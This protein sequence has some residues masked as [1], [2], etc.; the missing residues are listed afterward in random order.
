MR[1]QSLFNCQGFSN[2]HPHGAVTVNKLTVVGVSQPLLVRELNVNQTL[3]ISTGRRCA[4]S[5]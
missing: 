5:K 1:D 3:L 4:V 2:E